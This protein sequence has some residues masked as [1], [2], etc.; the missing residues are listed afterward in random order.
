[1]IFVIP[2]SARLRP[3]LSTAF[4]GAGL[5][6]SLGALV[7][8][9]G[10]SRAAHD[11]GRAEPAAE[12]TAEATP[13]A[14]FDHRD[15]IANEIADVTPAADRGSLRGPAQDLN[16]LAQAV[17]FEARGETPRG[18][19]AVA[20]VVLNRVKSPVFPKP[21]CAV[22]YQGAPSRRC[23]FSFACDGSMRHGLEA[24]AWD[25][26]RQVASRALSGVVA[27]DI[28]SATH[29]HTT[30]VDPVWGGQMLQVAQVGLHVFYRFN[31][32]RPQVRPDTMEHA[33][34]VSRPEDAPMTLAV[35]PSFPGKAGEAAI[36]A[37]LAG[38]A[39]AAEPRVP[40]LK[41]V[42]SGAPKPI[43]TAAPVTSPTSSAGAAV[44]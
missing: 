16:C 43:A 26:A 20:Q 14:A 34:L 39:P 7:M 44:S 3:L 13:A 30:S 32:H 1:L 2:A 10:M 21:V 36:A 38:P 5:G 35:A 17:Y 41:T 8:V 12:P 28:C 19:A 31:P 23:Q 37:S 40:A 27:A 4:A 29:F 11:L 18:Q 42:D 6:L 24:D 9:G 25:R 22:V 15:E 33:V